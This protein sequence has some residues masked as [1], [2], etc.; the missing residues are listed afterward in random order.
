M[1]LQKIVLGSLPALLL[2][3]ACATTQP[4]PQLI[5]ARSAYQ[6]ASKSEAAELAPD[7]LLTA[8]QA[9]D[10]AEAAHQDDPQ[11]DEEKHLAYVANRKAMLA[12][13]RG[14]LEKFERM[15]TSAQKQ[16]IQLQDRER[17]EA[18]KALEKTRE[19]LKNTRTAL[20]NVQAAMDKEGAKVDELQTKKKELEE[21]AKK[22]EVEQGKLEGA[23][24]IERDA[25][26]EAE[27]R[28]AAAIAS[29]EAIAKVKS[30]AKETIITLSG[31]VL[32]KTGKS[33]LLPLAKEKLKKVA[34]ALK[35]QADS[36]TIEVQGHTDSRGSDAD[37]KKLSLDRAA[38]VRVF[39]I[40]E[41]VPAERITAV[42]KGEAFP[43]ADNK[44]AEGRA[45]NRR[46]EIR[47]RNK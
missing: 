41:G 44:S 32:F 42:G 6:E 38:S 5:E 11:S 25:R 18:R 20:G 28:A 13:Q 4:S 23:L 14:S 15:G 16:Y 31:A 43:V 8:R 24:K 10:E 1:N 26:K 40:S 33:E 2:S 19:A 46:V 30:E 7:T 3:A 45:N 36:K 39:L 9:L 47:V 27:A 17:R 34:K 22:L 35:E 37:N 12:I 29:L 21:Q